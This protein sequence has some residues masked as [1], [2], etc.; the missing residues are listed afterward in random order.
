[1]CKHIVMHPLFYKLTKQYRTIIVK[2]FF[3]FQS[4]LFKFK[5]QYLLKT[6]NSKCKYEFYWIPMRIIQ[7]DLI[8]ILCTLPMSNVKILLFI[9]CQIFLLKCKNILK[10]KQFKKLVLHLNYTFTLISI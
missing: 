6:V 8:Q 7:E 9:Q 3:L 2:V 4:S 5:I 1:M 10:Q